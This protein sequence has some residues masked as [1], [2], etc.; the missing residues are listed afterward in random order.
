MSPTCLLTLLPCSVL[1]S[2]FL[3][4][5]PRPATNQID[6]ECVGTD[7]AHPSLPIPSPTDTISSRSTNV[8]LLLLHHLFA[9]FGMGRDALL[10]SLLLLT[11]ECEL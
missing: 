3:S 9:L 8:P 1:S 10:S 2:L 6:V 11:R 4:L 5:A 7:R